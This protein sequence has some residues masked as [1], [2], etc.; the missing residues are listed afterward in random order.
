MF[1]NITADNW[2]LLWSAVI[3]AIIAGGAAAAVATA[4]LRKTN[5]HQAKLARRQLDEQRN[6][7]EL[8]RRIDALAE[9]S[10][11]VMSMAVKRDEGFNVLAD[12]GMASNAALMRWELNHGEEKV[13]TA[14]GRLVRGIVSGFT[15]Y[16]KNP[17][18]GEAIPW[19]LIHAGVTIHDL[20]RL[21]V[22]MGTGKK[23]VADV[24]T[25]LKALT[26]DFEAKLSLA[27]VPG[28]PQP[29]AL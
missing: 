27:R 24:V 9:F 18:V 16:A 21:V 25:G 23:P 8:A 1:W 4:V 28:Y 3:G 29:D 17:A 6:Q 10:S 19:V 13:S 26:D 7:A 5:A 15:H 22:D 12:M 20:N 14:L 2:T 11:I